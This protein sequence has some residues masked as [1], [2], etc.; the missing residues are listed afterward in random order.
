M[1]AAIEMENAIAEF[2]KIKPV[3]CTIDHKADKPIYTLVKV[4]GWP[5][6]VH[7]EFRFSQKAGLFIELHAESKKYAEIAAAIQA[8]QVLAPHIEGYL[9]EYRPSRSYPHPKKWPS[10]SISLGPQVSGYV[11]AQ[12]MLKFIIATRA[13][14][15]RALGY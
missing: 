4:D 7:Y 6:A 1:P 2:E 14:I 12:A 10:L 5:Y 8:C 15:A 13:T 3:D 11:A 9:V